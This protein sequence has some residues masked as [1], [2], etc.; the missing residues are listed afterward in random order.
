MRSRQEG[1]DML[2]RNRNAARYGIAAIAALTLA[3]IPAAPA[4]AQLLIDSFDAAG[5]NSVAVGV[6]NSIVARVTVSAPV[7]ITQIAV[8]TDLFSAGQIKFLIFNGGTNTLLF[9]STPQAFGDTGLDYKFSVPFAPFTLSSGITY[10]IGG[11]A[12]V[13]AFWG[14]DT[15]NGDDIANNITI[16]GN[17]HFNVGNFANPTITSAGNVNP[18]IQLLNT[19][20]EP[21]SIALFGIGLLG[22]TFARRRRR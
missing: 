2:L 13:D 22:A 14:F 15:G 1:M 19:A 21:A 17:D 9:Q 18:H 3:S 11:V 16:D 7:T 6:G 8:R 10:A 4:N 20:P 5:S 12:N